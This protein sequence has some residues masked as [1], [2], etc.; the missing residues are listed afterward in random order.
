MTQPIAN[1]NG[2]MVYSDKEVA[3]IFNTRVN[4]TDGSWCDVSTGQ[5]V[6]VGQ[7][8]I[9]IGS[10]EE[11]ESEIVTLGP[12][13]FKVQNLE[14]RDV[15]ADLEVLPHPANFIELVITGPA[16]EAKSIEVN[17]Q[18]DTL[19]IRG[20]GGEKAGNGIT[21][22]SGRGGSISSIGR[23]HGAS[24]VIGSGSVIAAGRNIVVANN[25]K[26]RTKITVKVP[27]GAFINLSGIT[28]SSIIGDTQGALQVASCYGDVNAGRMASASLSVSGSSD[29]VVREVNGP[30]TANIMGSGDIRVQGGKVSAL[31]I[32]VMGSG[33]ASFNGQAETATLSVMGSG[34]IRVERVN[35]R[36]NKSV[37]GSGSIRVGNW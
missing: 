36:P 12:Q 31:A 26:N 5:V 23:V 14:V 1:I 20:E 27:M 28:G 34:D 22:I 11:S 8:Y 24:I 30:L 29:I 3:S 7:G 16:D 33:D 13:S 4:F 37:M 21:V 6:N 18:G 17:Q 10:P 2:K 35:T 9:S 15:L 19:V 32:N 25:D